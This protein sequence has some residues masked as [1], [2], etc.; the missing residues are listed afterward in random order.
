MSTEEAKTQHYEGSLLVQPDEAL[1]PVQSLLLGLQHLLAMD[2]YVVPFI[3][4]GILSLSV[5]ESAF[6]IQAT[7][8]AS[9]LGTLI[10]SRFLMK[11]PVAQGPSYVPIGAIA[12]IALAHGTGIDSL[13]AVFGAILVGSLIVCVLGMTGIVR[14]AINYFVPP[15]VGGTI[16]FVVGLSLIPIGLK[17]NIFTVHGAGTI[18]ENIILALVSGGV[19]TVCVMLGLHMGKKG[20]WLRIG[21]VIIALVAGCRIYGTLFF[22]CRSGGSFIF[23]SPPGFRIIP[24]QI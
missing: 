8:I 14:K 17:D 13:A 12:G 1:P 22:G 3:V 11:L 19:L 2:I 24:C 5:Q 20:N 21:S 9:G 23:G 7:F 16:I 10:Q 6:L 4:A 15:L 18:T